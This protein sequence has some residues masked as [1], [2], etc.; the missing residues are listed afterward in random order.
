MTGLS[1]DDL[2]L[3]SGDAVLRGLCEE[4]RQ[5]GTIV[6]RNELQSRADGSVLP[7]MGINAVAVRT[8][9]SESVSSDFLLFGSRTL[10]RFD[11]S[12]QAR[13]QHFSRIVFSYSTEKEESSRQVRNLVI[14]LTE[15]EARER[16]R[17][18]TLLHDDLQQT[19]AG[20]KVHIDMAA[21][22]TDST[23]YVADRLT[24]AATLLEE[25]IDRSR[26]LSHELNPPNLRR[27]P[28]ADALRDL[29]I[30]SQRTHGLH[31]QIEAPS[32]PIPLS[33]FAK[34]VVYRSIQELLFNV[35]KHANVDE[36]GIELSV[37][38]EGLEIVVRDSGTGFDV[39]KVVH[40]DSPTGLG[41]VS[42]RERLEAIGATLE[43][44]SLPNAGST[45]TVFLPPAAM[46]AEGVLTDQSAERAPQAVDGRKL[47]VVLVDDHAVIRQGIALL[48][49]E[50]PD[51]EV[52][53]EADSGSS[54]LS[55]VGRLEPDVVVMDLA[56]PGMSGDEATREILSLAPDTRVIGL[57]MHS[58]REAE[59]RMLAAGAAAYLPK[60]GPSDDLISAIRDVT[61]R[62]RE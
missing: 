62:E 20:I 7:R 61:P 55:L 16:S 57:S 38:E 19:L 9:E 52:V 14:R 32:N 21:R 5:T 8:L 47:S 11:P 24:T 30:Q 2:S 31:V 43:I 29:A 41:L 39:D 10:P 15:A 44:Q 37:D 4:A 27:R 17:I 1:E 53:G 18:A 12:M 60:A 49:N 51:L 42:V 33:D 34:L 46:R 48:L 58:E 6:T 56:M 35:A 25:A 45:F 13:L 23:A 40:S 3:I 28:F 36:A 50:E 54:A 26:N 22:R 59:E